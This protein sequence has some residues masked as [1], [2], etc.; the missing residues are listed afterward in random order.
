MFS[1]CKP[2]EL[3]LCGCLWLLHFSYIGDVCWKSVLCRRLKLCLERSGWLV[4]YRQN[5]CPLRPTEAKAWKIS[6]DY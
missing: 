6:D 1:L 5:Q 4:N 2:Y 3:A